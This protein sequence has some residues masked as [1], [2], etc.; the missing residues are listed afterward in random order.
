MLVQCVVEHMWGGQ[1]RVDGETLDVGK[2]GKLTCS[3]KQADKLLGGNAWVDPKNTPEVETAPAADIGPI[4]ADPSGRVLSKEETETK[5]AKMRE[6]NPSPDLKPPS[7][8]GHTNPEPDPSADENPPEPKTPA[9]PE[10]EGA[11]WPKPSMEMSQEDMLD[12]LVDL[13]KEGLTLDFKKNWAK[14][15]LL[16]V[17]KAGYAELDDGEE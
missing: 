14:A 9:K 10:D 8:D 3:K 16:K 5:L 2:D 1:V 4:L 7:D 13:E 17:I 6:E 11:D 12:L 15:K